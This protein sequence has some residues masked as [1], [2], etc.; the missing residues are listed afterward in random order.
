[1]FWWVARRLQV[2]MSD[3]PCTD[4]GGCPT[5]KDAGANVT[6]CT[7]QLQVSGRSPSHERA[8][9]GRAANDGVVHDRAVRDRAFMIVLFMIATACTTQLQVKRQP[10][11]TLN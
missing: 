6:V 11:K 2:T 3:R 8:A 10:L 4:K 9:H 5:A 1:M 7:M